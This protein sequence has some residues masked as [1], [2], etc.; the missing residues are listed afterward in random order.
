MDENYPFLNE[1]Q[2]NTLT[3]QW[4][5]KH[6]AEYGF[7]L[8]YPP[9]ASEITGIIYEPWHYRYVGEKFA[10]EITGRSITLE[11]YVIWRRGR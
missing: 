2:E 11:E 3:Q 8:R 10:K 4:L 1:W 6:A 9:D 5:M 7:I